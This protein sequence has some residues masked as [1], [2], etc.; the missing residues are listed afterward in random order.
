MAEGQLRWEN[1]ILTIAENLKLATS[2]KPALNSSLLVY[3]YFNQGEQVFP[4][5]YSQHKLDSVVGGGV[6]DQRKKNEHY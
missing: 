1:R 5:V 4:L 2:R 6:Q 3:S